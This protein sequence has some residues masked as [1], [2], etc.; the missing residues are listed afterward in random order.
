MDGY[1]SP[2]DAA[3]VGFRPEHCRVVATRVEGDHAYVLLDTG[4]AGQ[5]YLYG[6]NCERRNGQ[7]HELGSSNGGGWSATSDNGTLGTWSVWDE[8]PPGA[9]RI[10]IECA[11]QLSEHPVS[12]GAFLALWFKQPMTN[13]PR[14]TAIRINGAWVEL[15]DWRTQ[16]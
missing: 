9:D 7:W 12:G 15:T 4:S 8:T 2:E 13:E 5:P 16:L 14:V 1:Q 10:R 6:V 11:G 3:M